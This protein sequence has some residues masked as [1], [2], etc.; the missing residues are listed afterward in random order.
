MKTSELRDMGQA[1]MKTKAE[2]LR[3]ELFHLR[4]QSVTGEIQNPSRI[5]TVRKEIARML[6][7]AGEK[8]RTA[9]K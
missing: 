4:I 1:E 6:T 3:K 5:R 7:I 9:G 2:E 8:A